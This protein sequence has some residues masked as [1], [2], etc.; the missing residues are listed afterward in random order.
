MLTKTPTSL[1]WL[2][3]FI[4]KINKIKNSAPQLATFQVLAGHMRPVATVLDRVGLEGYKRN[5]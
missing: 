2:F 1:R 5:E 3:T 4:L